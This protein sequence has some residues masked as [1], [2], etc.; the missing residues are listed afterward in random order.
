MTFDFKHVT[1]S[2]Y[3]PTH[4]ESNYHTELMTRSTQN[5]LKFHLSA[6][7]PHESS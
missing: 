6:D 5:Y 3:T 2:K 4:I 1:P 7:P